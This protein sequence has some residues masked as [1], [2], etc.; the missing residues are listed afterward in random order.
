[1]TIQEKIKSFLKPSTSK[2]IISIVV[3]FY[4]FYAAFLI[5]PRGHSSSPLPWLLFLPL[6]FTGFFE[7]ILIFPYSYIIACAFVSLFN[8]LKQKRLLLIV[9][10]VI[11][12][13]LLG[14][15]EP[16]MNNTIN[17][18]DYSCSVDSDCVVKSISKGWCGNPQC[19]NQNWEYYD[20][21]INSVFAL[22]CIQPMLSCSC[23]KNKCE[24]KDLYKSTNLEDC[25]KLQD[26]QK[27]Q[28]IRIVSYNI[29]KT[30]E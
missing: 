25:E 11:F 9:A 22:S 29:N 20:S 12:I 17:R 7:L 21:M 15:D 1:M 8:I 3:L 4:A 10:I 6:M 5:S 2:I 19:V 14:V 23:A 28:C 16:L 24:S 13:L 26:Y 27:E 18:P 30:Q